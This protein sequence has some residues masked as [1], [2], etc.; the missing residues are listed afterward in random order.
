MN[1]SSEGTKKLPPHGSIS[2]G[3][4]MD[5]NMPRFLHRRKPGTYTGSI[6]KA[7]DYLVSEGFPPFFCARIRAVFL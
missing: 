7:E 4:E 3:G 2:G 1:V 5:K 6:L